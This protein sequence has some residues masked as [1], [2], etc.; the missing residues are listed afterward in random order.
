MKVKAFLVASILATSAITSSAAVRPRSSTIVV[1]SPENLPLLAQRDSVAMYLHD[2]N[3]GKTILY[4]EAQNGRALNTL[5]VTDPANIRRVA[6][7][8]IPATTAF[9]FVQPVGGGGV[10][11]RY[12]DGSGV[13]LLNLKHYRQPVLV[14]WASLDNSNSEPLGETGLLLASNEMVNQPA[15]QQFTAAREYKVIDTAN[16]GQPAL[17]ATISDVEQRLTKSD[18]GTLFLLNKDGVTVVRRLRVEQEH[19]LDLAVQRG[20]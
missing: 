13:A 6:Q 18:T 9:D 19:Q 12:R 8:E 14:Q 15:G 20:N 5:D 7:T 10:L 11:I 2:T 4:V 1:E 3:D 17:L 16:V